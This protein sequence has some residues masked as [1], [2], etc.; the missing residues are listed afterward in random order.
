MLINKII[1]T[2]HSIKH[3]YKV[4]IIDFIICTDLCIS[5]VIDIINIKI[6][7]LNASSKQLLTNF[8]NNF[9]PNEFLTLVA[10][11]IA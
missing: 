2:K 10:L 11:T 5:F 1:I 8:L 7:M 3:I 9:S 4:C 6:C